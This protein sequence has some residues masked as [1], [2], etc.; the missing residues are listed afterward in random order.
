[1][2]L[3]ALRD[4]TLQHQLKRLLHGTIVAGQ[5]GRRH[6]QMANWVVLAM[7]LVSLAVEL[8]WFNLDSLLSQCYKK[9]GGRALTLLGRKRL[10]RQTKLAHHVMKLNC[11]RF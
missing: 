4:V 7:F 8:R 11:R 5:Q 6:R 2:S 9:G 3:A 10:R 1:M